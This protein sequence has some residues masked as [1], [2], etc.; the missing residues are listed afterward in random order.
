MTQGSIQGS[1]EFRAR[2]FEFGSMRQG[3]TPQYASATSGVSFSQ[4][5]RLSS[6]PGWRAMAPVFSRR[7]TSFTALCVLN[8]ESRGDFSDGWLDSFRQPADRQQQLVVLRPPGHALCRGLAEVDEVPDLPSY[9]LREP[10][11]VCGQIIPWNF[12]LL[13]ASWKLGPA[14]A[15]GNVVVLKPAEQTPLTALRLG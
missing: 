9:T 12:P 6:G 11:G 2:A 14:L 8:E 4:T 7:F 15:C 13:M 3:K 5:S 10:V 1:R